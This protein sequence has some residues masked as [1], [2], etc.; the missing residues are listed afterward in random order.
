MLAE[1]R[2][3]ELSRWMALARVEPWGAARDDLR[4]GYIAASLAPAWMK[5]NGGGAF[6]VSDFMLDF[7]R[8]PDAPVDHVAL[9]KKLRAALGGVPIVKK[10]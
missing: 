6:A 9:S 8:D 7:T 4:A 1:M 5:K 3:S 2:P 10:N